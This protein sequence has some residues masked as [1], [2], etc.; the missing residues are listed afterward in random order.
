MIRILRYP[1]RAARTDLIRPYAEGG[2]AVQVLGLTAISG[3]PEK[4]LIEGHDSFA[5][6]QAVDS[7]LS[8]ATRG[9]APADYLPFSASAIA[10]YRP[11]LSYRPEEAIRLLPKA[12]YI[13]AS[14]YRIRADSSEEFAQLIGARRRALDSVNLDRPEIAYQVI[15]GD[16]REPTCFCRRWPPSSNWTTR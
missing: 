10:A 14:V 1:A 6:L 15:S 2:T 9:D 16:Q 13:N 7:A 8:S 12:R 11:G 4:W 3:P 5:S